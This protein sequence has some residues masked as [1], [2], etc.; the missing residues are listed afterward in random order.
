MSKSIDVRIQLAYAVGMSNIQYTIRNVPVDVDN[1][2]RLKAKKTK[3]TFNAT[4]VEVLRQSTNV[5]TSNPKSDLDWFY[6]S[7]GIG[8]AELD[9][10]AKQR[11]IDQQSWSS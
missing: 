6:G 10:F 9:E 4:I 3:Q 1:A 5:S 11:V 2:L 8:Q 7:G